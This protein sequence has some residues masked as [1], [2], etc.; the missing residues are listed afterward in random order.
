MRP[1]RLGVMRPERGELCGV[2]IPCEDA[3]LGIP[4]DD[5]RLEIP[6]D[7]AKLA[8]DTEAESIDDTSERFEWFENWLELEA[9]PRPENLSPC[10]ES[11]SL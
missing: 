2:M 5:A 6:C 10:A 11:R 1:E 8:S 4:C 7:D 9:T 3:R